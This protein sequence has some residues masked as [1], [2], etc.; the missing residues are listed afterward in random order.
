MKKEWIDVCS[1]DGEGYLP[2]ITYQSWRVAELR[3]CEELEV[4]N[5]D[6]MQKHDET[7]EVFV[8]LA[9]EC[10]L[11][12]GGNGDVISEI[13]GIKMEPLKIYNV[14]R[15]TF[16]THTPEKGSTVLIIENSNTDDNINSPTLKMIP[17]QIEQVREIYYKLNK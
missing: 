6:K 1:Y 16:H 14:K 11:F 5:L 4:K 17:E 9:G 15:G 12:T 7:D 3:Y 8:L 2:L 10:T 13:D